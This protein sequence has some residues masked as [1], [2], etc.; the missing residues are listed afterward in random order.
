MIRNSVMAVVNIM[1][2]GMKCVKKTTRLAL[3]VPRHT[4][5]K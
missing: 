5:D 4:W 2:R 3:G 1:K